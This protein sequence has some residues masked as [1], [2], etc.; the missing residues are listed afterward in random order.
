MLA[1]I[2]AFSVVSR[3]SVLRF[4]NSDKSIP[5][6]GLE[7]NVAFVLEGGVQRSGDHVRV[8]AQLI[9]VKTDRHLWAET[10]DRTLS[11][12]NLFAIQSE[13]DFFSLICFN[14]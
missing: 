14:L 1:R 5:E 2:N 13:H 4:R 7:L 12:T 10:F 11:T 8:N 9:D 6:I 3:T